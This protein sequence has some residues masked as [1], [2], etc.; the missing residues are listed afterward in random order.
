MKRQK[1]ETLVN[2]PENE[3]QDLNAEY[4]ADGYPK[5]EQFLEVLVEENPE[6]AETYQIMLKLCEA[7]RA[8]GGQAL[9]VGGSVR[10]YYFG[11]VPK[12]YDLE[13]Y[14]IQP[15]RI[16]E[17]LAEF[18]TINEVGESF[19]VI[20]LALP[21]G[22]DLDISLPRVDNKVA[23]G[24]KGFETRADPFM[25]VEEAAR[26][27]DFTINSLAA[28]PLT[29]EVYNYYGGLSDIW[30]RVLRVTDEEKFKED[31]LRVLRGLQF[32]SRMDLSIEPETREIMEGM[33]PELGDLP[34]ERKRE[35]WSKLLMKGTK[36]S[37]GLA[38]AKALG[39]LKMWHPDLD[40]L[41][42][43]P[44][45]GE[46]HPEGDVWNHTLM[47]VDVASEIKEAFGLT[48]AEKLNVMLAVLCHDLGKATTTEQ[49]VKMT[50]AGE[51]RPRIISH[52]HEE[53]GAEP[54]E[55]FLEQ[56]GF[57]PNGDE[58]Q[59]TIILV[60]KH[61][62][63]T[64]M[65]LNSLDKDSPA[66]K[67]IDGS[68]RR[69]AKRIH[70]A[71]IKELVA[72]ATADHLG[73]GPFTEA[74]GQ[75]LFNLYT[76]GQW[77]IERAAVLGVEKSVPKRVLTGKDLLR[78]GFKPGENVGAAMKLADDLRDEKKFSGL[79]VIEAISQAKSE[80]ING[81]QDEAEAIAVLE[82]LLSE[83]SI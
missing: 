62:A 31:P 47:S 56:I 29:G 16:K 44:Q 12:D 60:T 80:G 82:K 68:I 52:G 46:W 39:I 11:L 51:E 77:L 27:R 15:D 21:N 49:V 55:R 22:N 69:L 45:E 14:R 63:P 81:S 42:A 10:D 23:A 43:I 37:A 70:P 17:I 30:D 6:L 61:L 50:A 28:N 59:K 75:I 13:V 73:R 74:N 19:S 54:T 5:P 3:A 83:T 20:K 57:S 18:G 78:L 41:S 79:Q 36:P 67:K 2:R 25:S 65:H 66:A 34:A 72:V 76:A 38:A 24:H 26:R 4:F 33:A 71:T 1:L 58:A 32:I 9:L 40:L 64:M 53:A 8:E 35:E 7:F 48:E